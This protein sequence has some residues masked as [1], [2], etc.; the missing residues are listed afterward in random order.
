MNSLTINQQL[1]SVIPP[2]KVNILDKSVKNKMNN[3]CIKHM[4][5]YQVTYDFAYKDKFWLCEAIMP[6]LDYDI[7]S[8]S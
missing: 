4:L 1:L 3:M 8:K 2:S 5:P 7:I 6:Y